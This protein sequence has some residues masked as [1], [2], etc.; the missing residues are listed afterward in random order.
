MPKTTTGTTQTNV[1]NTEET[2]MRLEYQ[3]MHLLGFTNPWSF[4]F[5][6]QPGF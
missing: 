2:E 3:L 1:R 5:F 6:Q 4:N